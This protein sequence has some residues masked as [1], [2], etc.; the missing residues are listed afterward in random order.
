MRY[1]Y[2]VVRPSSQPPRRT[3]IAGAP[4][5][6]VRSGD[7][8]ALVSEVPAEDELRV[9]REDVLTH[10]QVLEEVIKE[11]AVLP[12]RF[13][14]VV[15]DVEDG[16]LQRHREA[17]AEL[18]DELEDMVEL[19]LRATYDEDTVMAE[20]VAE[21]PKIQSLREELRDQPED[22]TYYARI[23]LGELVAAA[24]EGKRER[25]AEQILAALGD[26]AAAVE[27]GEGGHER[28]ALSASF[29]VRRD[30]VDQ[31][32]RAVDRLGEQ[33]AGR[34]HF[35]YTGPLPPHSFVELPAE[36]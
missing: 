14:V 18:L 10:A 29:L 19:H 17:L 32:D 22:A 7:V 8:A 9:G 27:V 1:V 11:E 26:L 6:L 28:V 36:G 16:L 2:G 3:G 24:L 5:E 15:S 4:L 35:R 30:L 25:D 33:F 12:M 23:S 31:F 13:G 20:V 21:N 34:V